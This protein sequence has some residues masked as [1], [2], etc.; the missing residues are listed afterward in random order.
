MKSSL[1]SLIPF[2]QFL[3]N[4]LRLPTLSIL[5]SQAHILAGWRLETQLTQTILFVHFITPRHGLRRKHSFSL[6]EKACLQR[7]CIAT[8]VACCLRIRCR[9]NVFT[10]QL[11]SNG[12]LWFHYSG[13]RVSCHN[14]IDEVLWHVLTVSEFIYL[15]FI[16]YCCQ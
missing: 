7:R 1:H 12:H 8:D 14:I 16:L 15:W 6:V 9:R 10:E 2:L 4:H 3:L 5:C 11:P 13:F